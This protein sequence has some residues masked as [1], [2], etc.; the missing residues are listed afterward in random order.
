MYVSR[1]LCR[2][3]IPEMR[4]GIRMRVDFDCH[5]DGDFLL[6]ID[7]TIVIY[8]INGHIILAR[9][10]CNYLVTSKWM[11]NHIRKRMR[12][13]AGRREGVCVIRRSLLK[14]FL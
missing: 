3:R 6:R 4:I 14:V 5:C 2:V 9:N 13:L 11:S 10:V 12:V 8:H 1:S 7:L